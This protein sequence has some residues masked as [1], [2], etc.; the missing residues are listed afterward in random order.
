MK[1]YLIIIL[2][3]AFSCSGQNTDSQQGE[4]QPAAEF[5]YPEHEG[6][7][8]YI[9]DQ[10][11]WNAICLY[12]YGSQNDLGGKWPGIAVSG[13]LTAPDGTYKYF[14]VP[15][16]ARGC[17]E[18]L[19]FNNAGGGIQLKDEPA[20]SFDTQ[21]DFFFRVTAE[22]ASAFDGGSLLEV[23]VDDKPIQATAVKI[24]T[25][26]ARDRTPWHI[27]QVNPRLYGNSGAYGKIQAR[28]DDIASMGCN[29]L[30]LMPIYLPG[31]TKSIGSPYCIKDFTALNPAYGTAEELRNLISAAHGRRMKVMLDWV[32]NHTAWDC[33]W[34]TE[35]KDWYSQDS[36]GNIVCPTA[37][38]TW[39]DVAQLSYES[40]SLRQVMTDAM[41]YWVTE[42]DVDGFRCDYAHGPTGSKAGPM[43]EFWKYAVGK[44]R[45][46]KTDLVM[47][48][49]SDYVKM[50][51]DG[52]DIIYSRAAKAS[53]ESVFNGQ[54]PSSFFNA[55]NKAM[56]QAPAPKTPLLYVTNHDDA[57]SASPVTEFRSKE[58]ALAAFVLLRAL[59][60]STMLYGSQEVG[61]AQP[62]N[63]FTTL[64]LDWNANAD[65]YAGFIQ[66]MRT[67]R[68]FLGHYGADVYA[69]GPVV[70]VRY[71]SEAT[72]IMV[73][74]SASVVEASLPSGVTWSAQPY[75]CKFVFHEE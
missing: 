14:D 19:I 72:D 37:D 27:Y 12:M 11:G 21:A 53:L 63:F 31:N 65:Y 28:L 43:D 47:L 9:D 51:A 57:A 66:A 69:A 1:K 71:P 4:A 25:L 13:T 48:A 3:L 54:E 64:S 40:E 34:I 5:S 35:H 2:L 62:I 23:V 30:Y 70:I 55:Y 15:V 52:F 38:G 10:T 68:S 6:Y 7:R 20:I 74:T 60:S 33:A 61:Y 49:E 46:R 42:F 67:Y 29:V 41:L 50:Y 58:G 24:C 8:V 75:E 45:E 56:S 22:K 26:E 59:N 44:L 32:A 39:S 36:S 16:Q 73:N 17:T 18:K